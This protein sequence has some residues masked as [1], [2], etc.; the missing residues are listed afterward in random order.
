MSRSK[1]Q[2]IAL[3][4]LLLTIGVVTSAEA[5]T[6][7]NL[8]FTGTATCVNT[9]GQFPC[10][11]GSSPI[12]GTYSLDVTTHTIVGA[13]SF[14]TSTPVG[15][16]SSSDTGASAIFS[17]SFPPN[18]PAFQ[19][20]RQEGSSTFYEYVWLIYPATD[21]TEL[22]ALANGQVC[23]SEL[24]TNGCAPGY[25]VTGTTRLATST[26]PEPSSG[27]L[28]G[29]FMLALV[30]LGVKNSLFKGRKMEYLG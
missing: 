8:V 3:C 23:Y 22:G 7:E 9:S 16:I 20:I 4:C 24:A 14:S 13:W 11:P 12:T 28:L 19:I 10:S 25:T 21:T 5:D 29:V 15:V 30:G 18:D 6:I 26:V 17:A 27:M 1:A 2:R